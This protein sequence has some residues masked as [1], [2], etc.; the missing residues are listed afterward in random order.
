ML[1]LVWE[2][3]HSMVLD[4][5]WCR[6]SSGAMSCPNGTQRRKDGE[7][8]ATLRNEEG[9]FP[10]S[11]RDFAQ[12]MQRLLLLA[13]TAASLLIGSGASAHCDQNHGH[14]GANQTNGGA[15]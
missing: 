12:S 13:L 7:R 2:S 11:E 14:Q 15:P 4:K 8:H 3:E 9:Q 5:E 10:C 6:K 1:D